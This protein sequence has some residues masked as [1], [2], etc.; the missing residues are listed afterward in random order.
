MSYQYKVSQWLSLWGECV[1]KRTPTW[2]NGVRGFHSWVANMCPV[3]SYSCDIVFR[4]GLSYKHAIMN[5]L[6]YYS[7]ILLIHLMLSRNVEAVAC[8]AIFC[9]SVIM[10]DHQSLPMWVGEE[11]K[12]TRMVCNLW[13]LALSYTAV[14]YTKVP[15]SQW[16]LSLLLPTIPAP[17]LGMSLCFPII[18][19]G[20]GPT[21]TTFAANVGSGAYSSNLLCNLRMVVSWDLFFFKTSEPQSFFAQKHDKESRYQ[22]NCLPVTFAY[23]EKC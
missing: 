6:V 18:L 22:F 11:R 23:A 1:F 3:L 21:A 16:F 9:R 17:Y 10:F 12:H 8:E 13:T 15:R 4:Y 14:R 19:P 7:N 20:A 2:S 5:P